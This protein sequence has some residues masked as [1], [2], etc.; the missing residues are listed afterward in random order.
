MSPDSTGANIPHIPLFIGQLRPRQL[1][2][3]WG[4]PQVCFSAT[5]A[6][7]W[8]FDLSRLTFSLTCYLVLPSYLTLL[9]SSHQHLWLSSPY[10][11]FLV[12]VLCDFTLSVKSL[13]DLCMSTLGLP[14]L[15]CPHC[16]REGKFTSGNASWTKTKQECLYIQE[17]EGK[18]LCFPPFHLLQFLF[19]DRKVF[20]ERKLNVF[21]EFWKEAKGKCRLL[22]TPWGWQSWEKVACKLHGKASSKCQEMKK[23]RKNQ[24]L[25]PGLPD[26]ADTSAGIGDTGRPRQREN[27]LADEQPREQSNAGEG[28]D[29]Q[30]RVWLLLC[31][32]P[33]AL[34]IGIRQRWNKTKKTTSPEPKT[35]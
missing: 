2:I 24:R 15:Y 23:K 4:T 33:W 11:A 31:C 20:L 18:Q 14:L 32:F 27:R 21:H 26:A 19:R 29:G 10:T 35:W 22:Q 8:L 6:P 28:R 5:P 1:L 17:K 12:E 25:A 13:P 9:S 34:P 30:P 3:A 16:S 7:K